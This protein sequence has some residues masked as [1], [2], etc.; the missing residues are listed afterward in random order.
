MTRAD[1]ERIVRSVIRDYAVPSTIWRITLLSR[2]WNIE[3]VDATGG[4]T[5]L[6]VA[7]SSPQ[8]LRSSVMAA[9]ELD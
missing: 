9:L 4:R 6:T 3:L 8:Y 7:D 5:T 2:D 1:V